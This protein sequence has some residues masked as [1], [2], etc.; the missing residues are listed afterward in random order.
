MARV[1][2]KSPRNARPHIPVRCGRS[3]TTRQVKLVFNVL[4]GDRRANK[5]PKACRP[6]RR[7]ISFRPRRLMLRCRA[8]ST[9]TS[10]LLPTYARVNLAFER[11]E[12]VWLIAT[13]GDRYLDF[14]SG[15]AV[16][17]LGHSHPQ[18]VAAL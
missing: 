3:G 17:A 16:N 7:H 1:G 14:T 13:S 9:V 6:E 12:G 15:V 4:T 11:G 8:G 5:I 10:H 2:R 18:L